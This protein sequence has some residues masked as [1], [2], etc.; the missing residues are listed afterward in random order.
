M[1]NGPQALYSSAVLLWV[2][3][4]DHLPPL[5]GTFHLTTS[6]IGPRMSTSYQMSLMVECCA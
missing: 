5:S 2:T 1:L 6:E 3:K 4:N